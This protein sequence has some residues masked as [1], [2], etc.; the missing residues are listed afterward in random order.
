M[1]NHYYEVQYHEGGVCAFDT[2]EKAIEYADEYGRMLISEIGGC[3]TDFE[4]CWFCG[5]WFDCCELNVG[6]V[7]ARCDIAIKDHCGGK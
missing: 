7:C 1:N 4:K 6:G 5:E 2:L 3:W